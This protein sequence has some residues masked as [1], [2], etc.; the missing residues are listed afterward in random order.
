[1]VERQIIRLS[2]LFFLSQISH[3]VVSQCSFAGTSE[4]GWRLQGHTYRKM[5]AVT[6]L[7]CAFECHKEEICQSL[8]FVLSV[9][10]CEFNNRTKEAKPKEFVPD[11]DAYYVKRFLKRVALGSIPE[12]PAETC[13][14][15]KMSEGE[16]VSGNYWLS[17]IKPGMSIGAYCDMETEDVDECSASSPVC[18]ANSYCYNI[19]GSYNC[20]C[21]Q[22]YSGDHCQDINECDAS[23]SPCDGNAVCSNVVGS[24][25]CSCNAGFTGDGK[26]CN[27]INECDVSPSPCD[28]NASCINNQGSYECSCQAGFT[29]DGKTCNDINECVA[30]PSPCDGNAVCINNV[31]SYVCSCNAGFTGNGITCNDVNECGASPSPC[32]GNGVCTNNEGSYVCSCNA[33]YTGDGT[34][35]NDIDECSASPSPCD[36]NANCYNKGGS[37]S[38]FCYL[39][40]TG[41]G[42]TCQGT[43]WSVTATSSCSGLL[44]VRSS[45]S[46][47]IF[48]NKDG[49]YNNDMNCEWT[50]SANTNLRL[51]FF[52]FA[53][54]ASLDSVRV[55]DGL[56]ASS[57]LVG[58]YSGSSIPAAITSSSNNL[59]I[60]FITDNSVVWNGFAASYHVAN[61]IRLE[62]GTTP[63]EGRVEIFRENQWGTVCDDIWQTNTG[64][65]VCRQLG[66]P[67]VNSVSG[68]AAF[69]QGTGPIW[70]DDVQCTSSESSIDRCKFPG[71]EIENCGHHE[72]AGVECSSTIP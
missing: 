53:T 29:G 58:T 66:F 33:G 28:G 64:H 60:T 48:S 16:A 46:G 71:W 43:V 62:G 47:I 3:R 67:P 25:A 52:R 50:L 14:E 23:P 18:P 68:S 8:N 63:L 72:D 12:L 39:G 40:F 9:G 44:V 61:S 42:I 41:D 11:Q 15:I 27:D 1:M 32:G 56:S 51:V 59:F 17:T 35:C 30:W 65:V 49:S 4:L 37:Y 13:K 69:G 45:T 20:T 19:I 31:G 55:Y 70:M 10:V 34:S 5:K 36:P 57:S 24:Y 54:E 26:S 2:V 7:D 22:G 38:C 6:G 21:A